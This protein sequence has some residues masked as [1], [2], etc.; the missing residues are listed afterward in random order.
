M[1]MGR[2]VLASGNAGK[3]R[4][5]GELLAPLGLDL[6]PQSEWRTPEADEN[7]LS[8]VENALIKARHAA[9]HTGLPAIADDSGLVV[10]ALGGEPGIHSARF[11]REG[12]DAANNA[13]LLT[14][15]NTLGGEQRAA[16][17]YCAMVMM[18]HPR[19][20]APVISTG[21]WHGRILMA[22]RGDGGFGYDPLFLVPGENCTSAELPVA[23]KNRLSHRGQAVAGLL[24]ALRRAA[25]DGD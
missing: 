23:T 10:P 19:D 25:D 17:F 12:T 4:E 11:S 5:L 3:L 16:H 9:A 2:V 14:E 20:P 8:F 13:R 21:Q 18:R 24:A 1:N 6:R 7:G 22:P 15:M